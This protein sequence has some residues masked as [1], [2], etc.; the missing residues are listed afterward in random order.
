MDL[1]RLP[2]RPGSPKRREPPACPGDSEAF[3]TGARLHIRESPDPD[4]WAES[5]LASRRQAA[6][7]H[8][9]KPG[10]SL[11]GILRVLLAIFWG[12]L[13]EALVTVSGGVAG[14]AVYYRPPSPGDMFAGLAIG[15]CGGC[16]A[17][18]GLPLSYGVMFSRLSRTSSHLPASSL[19]AEEPAVLALRCKAAMP[20]GPGEHVRGCRVV[21]LPTGWE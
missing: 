3:T 17:I 4:A 1:S 9:A 8:I 16:A 7:A 18:I 15:Y 11:G 6:P 20:T 21:D 10:G 13:T 12:L 5:L 14:A 2:Q 19:A